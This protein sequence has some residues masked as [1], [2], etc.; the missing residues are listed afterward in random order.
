MSSIDD[1]KNQA[2]NDA[3]LTEGEMD[4]VAGGLP[5]VQIP[6][7]KDYIQEVEVTDKFGRITKH[8]VQGVP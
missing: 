5:G 3:E 7:A 8:K 6:G 1:L 4:A 2:E